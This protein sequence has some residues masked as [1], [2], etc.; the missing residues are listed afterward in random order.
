MWL[1]AKTPTQIGSVC[2]LSCVRL[3]PALFHVP[4]LA[5]CLWMNTAGHG[6]QA[7]TRWQQHWRG[8]PSPSRPLTV[9]D[10]ETLVMTHPSAH[11]SCTT[12]AARQERGQSP[13]EKKE[14]QAK[15]DEGARTMS[16]LPLAHGPLHDHRPWAIHYTTTPSHMRF[17]DAYSVDQNKSLKT[18]RD[19]VTVS[20]GPQM[21]R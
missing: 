15:R 7:Q 5:Y 4:P 10:K 14:N 20:G 18:L 13:G 12:T 21:S 3:L 1:A 19:A 9:S 2:S 16:Q 11:T 17:R 6:K 8:T